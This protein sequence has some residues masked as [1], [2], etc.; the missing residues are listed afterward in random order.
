MKESDGIKSKAIT[1]IM[2]T[3][4]LSM[5][6]NIAPVHATKPI[7]VSGNPS[8]TSIGLDEVRFANGNLILDIHE[9]GIWTGG[10]GGSFVADPCRVVM[11]KADGWYPSDWEFR[12]YTAIT[13]F[14]TCTVDGRTGGLV[15]RLTGKDSGPGTEWSG[16]W[17][18]LKATG[19]L[20]G[21][22]GQGTYDIGIH[23]QGTY[24]G[25]IHFDP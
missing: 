8:Y 20:E 25:K 12:W 24:E 9:A 22:H 5:A 3:L 14:E 17:V 13:T 18:I 7:P 4:F 1:T 19:E 10:I 16:K 15:M 11:H 2:L 21:I 6:F 23:G